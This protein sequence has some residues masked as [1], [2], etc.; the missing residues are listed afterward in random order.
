M[1]YNLTTK[2]LLKIQTNPKQFSSSSIKFENTKTQTIIDEL[3]RLKSEGFIFAKLE[4]D[5]SDE[6][7]FLSDLELSPR[8]LKY[9]NSVIKQ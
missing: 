6:I 3:Y 5:E 1:E 7:V 4:K 8:G 2:I 9:L